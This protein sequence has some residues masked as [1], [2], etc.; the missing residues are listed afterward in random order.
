MTRQNLI[1]KVKKKQKKLPNNRVSQAIPTTPVRLAYIRIYK[2]HKPKYNSNIVATLSQNPIKIRSD[3]AQTSCQLFLKT[4]SKFGISL[5]IEKTCAERMY[6]L[7]ESAIWSHKL[8]N[9]MLYYLKLK[10]MYMDP[11]MAG[12]P[13]VGGPTTLDP[14]LLSLTLGQS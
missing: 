3:I 5:R 9:I 14:T 6:H 12:R 13:L 11:A 4:P 7:G 8:S 1:L 2:L 10:N